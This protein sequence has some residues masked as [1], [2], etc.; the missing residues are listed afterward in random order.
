MIN[1]DFVSPTKIYFGKDKEKN[2][3]SVIKYL[4]FANILIVYGKGSI[5]QNGLY[6]AV[7]NS[8]EENHITYKELSNIRANPD[9]SKVNEGI[10]II[11]REKINFILAI[12]GGSVIDTAKS[13]AVAYYYEGNPFDLNLHKCVPT[14]ALPVGVILTIAAS[15]SELSDSCVV[16]DDSTGIKA[17][18][19]SDL[20]RPCFAIMNPEITFSVDK[21]QTG[22]GVVDII[23]HSLERYF[24]PGNENEVA[25]NLALSIIK[26]TMYY[27]SIAYNNP[28]NYDARASLMLL[29]SYSHNGL[30]NLGKNKTMPIHKIEH[31]LSAYNTEI[32][33]GAGLAVLIPAWMNYVYKKDLQ[34]F[35]KFTK[36]IFGKSSCFD[37]KNAKSA[38]ILIKK[39][40]HEIGMP[41]SFKDINLGRN[42]IPSLLEKLYPI[43]DS[44][45]GD[46]SIFPL[47][48]DDLNKIFESLCEE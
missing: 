8:L 1:F 24:T 47:K 14:N 37:I 28:N 6:S 38:G 45:I 32:A 19:N 44:T 29:G 27:G 35:S 42:D 11:R 20:V 31:A 18:F 40:F 4:G 13:I 48:K 41:T 30:T 26:D 5:K 7:I 25:D 17:G 22:Y 15:G 9:I 16:M 23:S 33:H 36:F 10:N 34:K 2:V 43:K 3:G 12:G 46:D 39:F 21:K